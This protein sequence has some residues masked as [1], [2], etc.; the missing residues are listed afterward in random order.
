MHLPVLG[1]YFLKLFM[2]DF[3]T[4][5]IF[6]RMQ[7]MAMASCILDRNRFQVRAFHGTNCPNCTVELSGR[8]IHTDKFAITEGATGRCCCGH[9]WSRTWVMTE[10]TLSQKQT[11]KM[12]FLRRIHGLSLRAKVRSCEICKALVVDTLLWMVRSQP[13]WFCHESRMPHERLSRQVLLATPTG[14]LPK[15]VQG[16]RFNQHRS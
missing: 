8:A 12:V 7:R 1:L 5:L 2:N 3:Q 16:P 11:A 6:P 15:F 13:R 4:F 14:K 10:R 9:I